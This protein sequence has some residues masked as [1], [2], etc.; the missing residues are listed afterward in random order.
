[1]PKHVTNKAF[2]SYKELWTHIFP[3]HYKD[4]YQ[5]EKSGL[6]GGG[7]NK[8]TYDI[9]VNLLDL[10]S[11]VVWPNQN[12]L[13]HSLEYFNMPDNWG[14]L[15][16][17]KSTKARLF[18]DSSRCTYIDAGF[19]GFLTIEYRNEGE[20]YIEIFNGQPI[21]Q[22]LPQ[23]TYF[24]VDPYDGKYQDQPNRPIEAITL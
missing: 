10:E 18:I 1:M 3:N 15:I 24:A 21:A 11:I 13:L 19:K 17:N 6:S 8:E 7:G 9:H 22:I 23:K 2:Q 4:R 20:E 14:A 16:L 12:I 5:H